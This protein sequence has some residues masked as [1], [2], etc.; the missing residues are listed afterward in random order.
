MARRDTGTRSI[1]LPGGGQPARPQQQPARRP[2]GPPPTDDVGRAMADLD[3]SA[4]IRDRSQLPSKVKVITPQVIMNIVQ[5]VTD[6]F[7]M[8][9]GIDREEFN[10]LIMQQ[11]QME[12]R[13]QQAN[14]KVENYKAEYKKVYDAFTNAQN[15]LKQAQAGQA[16]NEQ[17]LD[18]YEQQIAEL[19]QRN[20]AAV[21]TYMDLQQQLDSVTQQYS[22][23]EAALQQRDNDYAQ[24]QQQLIELE[25]GG[26]A[27]ADAQAEADQLRE[28]IAQ[29]EQQ[30]ADMENASAEAS[31]GINQEASLREQAERERD[32][33][34]GQLTALQ[35]E[36]DQVRGEL[37]QTSEGASEEA[38]ALQQ[39]VEDLKRQLKQGERSHAKYENMEIE[40]EKLRTQE[41]AWLEE[42]RRL[43]SQLSNETNNRRAAEEKLKAI[44]MGETLPEAS[45]AV[46]E[47]AK[48]AE[49]DAQG[50]KQELDQLKKELEKAK[51]GASKADEVSGE[52]AQA[53]SELEKTR[54]DLKQLNEDLGKAG[55]AA[56]ELG[57]LKRKFENVEAELEGL[58]ASE[59]KWL[60]EKRR[61]AA[62]LSNETNLRREL[63]QKMKAELADAQSENE[64]GKKN[65]RQ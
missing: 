17:F 8:D 61:M 44:E 62:Q 57:M 24:L 5:S 51:A 20:A 40:L 49:A 45:K 63:E 31:E 11:T 30:L 47:R 21:D 42:K 52:L 16:G 9:A 65:S 54:A 56:K 32:E 43:A 55:N 2:A 64:A 18:Q 41:G 12:M 13:L 7:G 15:L 36:L 28:Q 53:K 35:A 3:A 23:L 4:Q 38:Q 27:A 22:A 25:Q 59:G 6:K 50:A 58:R 19:Q 14:E 46:E 29:L 33:L 48:K 39:Q 10:Q 26:V 34:N 1:K 37:A 60:E